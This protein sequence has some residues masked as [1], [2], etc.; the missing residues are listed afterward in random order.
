MSDRSQWPTRLISTQEHAEEFEI[1][2]LPME[3][4]I[5]M[6]WPLTIQAWAMK[7][8]DVSQQP[9]RRDVGCLKRLGS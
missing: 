8:E 6:V 1:V 9:F 7:G 4:L 5:G 2:K 3:E